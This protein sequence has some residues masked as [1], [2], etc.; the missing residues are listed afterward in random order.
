M[1]QFPKRCGSLHFDESIIPRSCYESDGICTMQC[2]PG[3]EPTGGNF[4]LTCLPEGDWSGM[5][6]VCAWVGDAQAPLRQPMRSRLEEEYKQD[7][8]HHQQQ[9]EQTS[10]LEEY[11]QQP[12]KTSRLEEY[13]QQPDRI[14]R[15]EEDQD[16]GADELD[17]K[18]QEN[19][20]YLIDRYPK[21]AKIVARRRAAARSNHGF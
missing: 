4:E 6:L 17:K 3:Y 18:F 8:R 11:Q 12:E 20:S 5:P 2:A 1:E 7:T 15:L 9:P 16:A 10:R 13:Q 19:F 14:S 21:L